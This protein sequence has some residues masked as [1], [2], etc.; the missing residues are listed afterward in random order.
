MGPTK[1]I[2]NGQLFQVLYFEG[3]IHGLQ[4]ELQIKKKKVVKDHS[5]DFGHMDMPSAK[6][7]N[8]V[9]GAGLEG[10]ISSSV[11]NMLLCLILPIIQGEMLFLK[12]NM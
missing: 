11:L 2:R 6:K 8:T 12:F 7:W 10:N 4:N 1:V 3:R 5:K 9:G